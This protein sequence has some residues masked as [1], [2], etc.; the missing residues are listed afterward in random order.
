MLS[1]HV[2]ESLQ[3][4]QLCKKINEHDVIFLYHSPTSTF[5]YFTDSVKNIS[6]D[7]LNMLSREYAILYNCKRICSVSEQSSA[8]NNSTNTNTNA[9]SNKTYIGTAKSFTTFKNYRVNKDKQSSDNT[10]NKAYDKFT[11]YRYQGS[12][13]NYSTYKS[14][15]EQ[16]TRLETTYLSWMVYKKILEDNKSKEID[17]NYK[18]TDNNTNETVNIGIVKPNCE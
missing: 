3:D 2:I 10:V 8:D 12:L 18:D 9:N 6:V 1:D 15:R 5:W 16:K 17:I 7:M 11:H 4:K 13:I 14:D